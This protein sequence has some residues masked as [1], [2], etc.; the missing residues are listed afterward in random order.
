M[1]TGGGGGAGS[2]W[3]NNAPNWHNNDFNTDGN[4]ES[5]P[6]GIVNGSGHGASGIVVI[7]YVDESV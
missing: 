2:Y 4:G 6:H 7:R 3:S 5:L 1:G